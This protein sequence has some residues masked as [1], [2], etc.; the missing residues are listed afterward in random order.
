MHREIS[1]AIMD[2]SDVPLAVDLDGTLTRTDSL[3]EQIVVA[4]RHKPL[5]LIKAAGRLMY[6]KA[7]FKSYLAQHIEAP[8]N[9]IPF[10]PD[11]LRFIER[12][13]STGRKIILATASHAKTAEAVRKRLPVFVDV[14][15]TNDQVNMSAERKHDAL[16]ALYGKEGFDYIGNSSNDMKVWTAARRAYVANAGS[17]LEARLQK[18]GKLAGVFDKQPGAVGTWVKA[19]RLHQ[20]LKNLLVFVPILAAH[21]FSLHAALLGL[22]AFLSFSLCAS[23]VY[24]LNDLL[25]LET[26]RAHK[27]KRNRPLAAGTLS[28]PSALIAIPILLFA[29]AALAVTF[30]PLYFLAVVAIYYVM[31]FVYSFWLKRAVLI[32]V[33]ILAALYTLRLAAGAFA[34]SIGLSFWLIGFSMFI[35]LS[36]A[37][38]KRYAELLNDNLLKVGEPETTHRRG[39]LPQD[40]QLVSSLGSA[41]GYV[42]VLVLALYVRDPEVATRYSKPE[43]IILTC[44]L[45]L[46]WISRVWLIT[47][48]GDM[49]NDPVVFAIE[50][51][52]SQ[53]IGALT[54]IIFWLAI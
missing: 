12:E 28:I 41:A 18:T 11:V 22:I 50:D 44:P 9:T 52:V 36:L 48:R 21:Q 43:L 42:S 6:G 19:L 2:T 49:H 10:N 1:N 31:T 46:L 4:L 16:I 13:R 24:L 40:L 23:S 27:Q 25:D 5:V 51:R 47:H 34:L 8:L 17:L 32:D 30:L 26:D 29:A 35:F 15:C 54:V 38:V 45:I 3:W 39:Y 7:R 33:L 53:I 20:W 14:L 37:F